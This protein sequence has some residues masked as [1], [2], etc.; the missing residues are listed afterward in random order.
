MRNRG[1]WTVRLVLLSAPLYASA[2]WMH[3][4][5]PGTPRTRE[6]KPNLTAPAPRGPD[7]KPDFRVSGRPNRRRCPNSCPITRTAGSVPPPLG[8]ESITKYFANILADFKPQEAPLRPSAV[9]RTDDPALQCLPT[10]MP[11]FDTHPSPRKFVQ[12]PGLTLILNEYDN[13]F[14]QIFTDG[15]KLPEDPEPLWLGSSVG[16][17]DG[18]TL[19][20]DT[21]GL[22][23]R[24][25]LDLTG[26]THSDQLRITER[27]RRTSFGKIELQLTLDDPQTFTKPLTVKFNWVLFPDTDLLEAFCSENEKDHSHIGA[28]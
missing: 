7:G 2:Q 3:Y 17:W 12:T 26:H 28:K 4:P 18:D 27:F 16:R 23:G 5:T 9:V 8:S 6:G 14:R 20:V 1:S 19:V 13:T 22:N 15:R 11:M 25:S 24:R 21:G 10:G